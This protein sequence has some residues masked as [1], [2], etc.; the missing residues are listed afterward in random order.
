VDPRV[1]HHHLEGLDEVRGPGPRLLRV[2]QREDGLL[3]ERRASTGELGGGQVVRIPARR[4]GRL[5][6]LG[7]PPRALRLG[8]AA[9][10]VAVRPQELLD[11]VLPEARFDLQREERHHGRL[12]LPQPVVGR[13]LR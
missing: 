8:D 6:D 12:V 9:C 2:V 4:D 10:A 11:P 1:R 7:I 13:R 3:R 5:H